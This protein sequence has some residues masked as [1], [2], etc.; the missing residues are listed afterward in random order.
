MPVAKDDS[1]E[2]SWSH[3]AGSPEDL[4]DAARRAA[5]R[6]AAAAPLPNGY[7]PDNPDHPYDPDRHKAFLRAESARR[8]VIKVAETDG[9]RSNLHDVDELARLSERRLKEIKSIRITV[10]RPYEGDVGVE[11]RVSR[12]NGLVGEV[13]GDERAWTAGVR[14]ELENILK[15]RKRLHAPLL[16]EPWLAGIGAC[17]AFILVLA[18]VTI[19]LQWLSPWERP[20]R[21]AVGLTAA[22]LAAAVIAFAGVASWLRLEL[23]RSGRPRYERW[24]RAVL[25]TTWTVILGVAAS[26]IY[27]AFD[28]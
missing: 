25:V 9:Y 21:N 28:S 1:T 4:A 27:G 22:T 14:H 3:W 12:D 10:G 2:W 15:P 19:P 23:L 11:I 7:D 26:V 8:L 5:E 16:T 18:A 17:V 24:R 20:T 13:Y 6:V